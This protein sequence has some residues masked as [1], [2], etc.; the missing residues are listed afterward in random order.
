MDC[1]K[2]FPSLEEGGSCLLGCQ[3]IKGA[4]SGPADRKKLSL[5][6]DTKDAWVDSQVTANPPQT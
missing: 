1:R 5:T 4:S 6:R 3:H 2:A